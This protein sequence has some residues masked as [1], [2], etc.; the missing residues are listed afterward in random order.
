VAAFR[1]QG[2]LRLEAWACQL[3]AELA[4]DDGD[5]EACRRYGRAAA[6]L[7]AGVGCRIGLARAAALHPIERSAK[8]SRSSPAKAR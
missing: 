3:A 1:P 7:F 8:R 5:D 4:R 6:D 2:Y